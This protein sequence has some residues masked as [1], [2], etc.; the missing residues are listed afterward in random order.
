MQKCYLYFSNGLFLEGESFGASGTATLELKVCTDMIGYEESIYDKAFDGSAVLFTMSE[1]GNVGACKDDKPSLKATIVRNYQSRP[2]N[3]LS[4]GALDELFK[5]HNILAVS[6]MDTRE[7]LKDLIRSNSLKVV[8]STE[9]TSAE[10][11][12][13]RL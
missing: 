10:Q 1:I 12:K 11:L 4:V 3:Y 7:I 9:L 8:I 5:K 13:G 2:S 6:G